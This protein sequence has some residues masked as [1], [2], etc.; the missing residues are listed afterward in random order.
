MSSRR[1]PSNRRPELMVTDARIQALGARAKATNAARIPNVGLSAHWK[2]ARPNERY[3]PPV[4][5]GNDSWGIAVAASWQFFDGSRTKA[6]V[7][8]VHAE[9]SALQ[10]DRGELERRILLEVESARLELRAALQA[11]GCGR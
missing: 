2:Y 4:D 10:A 7:A 8:T 1:G 3:L 5:E 9:Q 6:R 11:V